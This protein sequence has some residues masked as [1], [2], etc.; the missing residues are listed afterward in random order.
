MCYKCNSWVLYFAHLTIEFQYKTVLLFLVLF[1][2][3]KIPIII[4]AVAVVDV[5]YCY[6]IGTFIENNY[7]GH[8]NFL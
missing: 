5:D 6:T 1:Q 4:V 8:A 3:F 2:I 7:C